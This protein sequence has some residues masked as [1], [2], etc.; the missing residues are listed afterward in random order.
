[1]ICV[2]LHSFLVLQ[3]YFEVLTEIVD[4]SSGLEFFRPYSLQCLLN[5][6]VELSNLATY[7]ILK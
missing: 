6:H 1:M 3:Y 5:Y 2:L 4:I 7:I